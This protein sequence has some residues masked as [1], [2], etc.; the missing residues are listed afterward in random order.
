MKILKPLRYL[1]LMTCILFHVQNRAQEANND[2]VER[3]LKC[4]GTKA[5]Y[6]YAYGELLKMLDKQFPKTED[7]KQGWSFLESNK[8]KAV[9]EMMTLLAPIYQ[10]NFSEQEIGKM[11]AFYESDTGKQL[12]TDRTAM[13][14]LQKEELNSFYNTAL[15]VKIIEK[16]NILSQA[17]SSV[18]ENWSRDLYETALSLLK[19]E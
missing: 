3:Y 7:N 15:G 16:Q 11:T 18:S 8:E 10:D 12:V 6:E 4:N 13:S 9:A 17:I 2:L 5:Q 14:A 1:L 19:H